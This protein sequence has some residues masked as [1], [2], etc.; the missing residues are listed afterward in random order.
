MKE[1]R[2]V[3]IAVLSALLATCAFAQST[4]NLDK[5]EKK[6]A[7]RIKPRSSP[8]SRPDYVRMKQRPS[9]MER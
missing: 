4:P 5:R 2:V 8:Q 1:V 6:Q 9:P 3:A 7:D